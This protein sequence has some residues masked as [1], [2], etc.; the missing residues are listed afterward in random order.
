M[1]HAVKMYWGS[2]GISPCI[3]SSPFIILSKEQK[4]K[5]YETTMLLLFYVIYKIEPNKGLPLYK[6][7]ES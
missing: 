1:Y 3:L 4:Y 6:F 5:F 7:M 2:G